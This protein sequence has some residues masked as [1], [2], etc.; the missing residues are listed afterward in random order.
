MQRFL[1][2]AALLTGAA[3]ATDLR[4]YPSFTEVRDTVRAQ[5]TTLNIPLPESVWNGLIPGTLDLDGLNFSQVTQTSGAS[6]LAGLEGKTVTL[7]EP[8]R[9]AQVVTLVRARD[10]LVRDAQGQYRTARFEDLRFS[11]AP[12]VG[13]QLPAQTLTYTLTQPGS[14]T[15]SYLTRAVTW[16]ARYTLRASAAGARL[17]ALADIRNGTELPYDVKATELYAG[18]VNLS[19][20]PV[21]Y[22]ESVQAAPASARAPSAPRIG[23]EGELGGLYRYALSSA[24]TLPASSTVTLPFIRPKLTGFERYAGLSTGFS[25]QSSEGVMSRN[26]RL[27]AGERLPAGPLTVR[28]DGRVVGQTVISDTA[29]GAQVGLSLGADPDVRYRRTVQQLSASKNARG[30]VTKVTY[31]VTYTFESGRERAV[32]AEVREWI[33]GPRV[34]IDTLPARQ[35]Q[36]TAELRADIPAGGKVSKSFTV[37]I[38]QAS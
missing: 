9:G 32:R 1:L 10:L 3:S 24:F 27:K 23:A 26:Y 33:G 35:E 4:I 37:V 15:L 38:D 5:S 20:N 11:G 12:P 19:G 36:A 14:G 16:S 22:R 25:T 34:T 31:R 18:E 29:A 6:W 28:E 8:G 13:A 7:E 21:M 2:L 17:D 30:D